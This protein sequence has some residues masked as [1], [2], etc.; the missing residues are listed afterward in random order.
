MPFEDIELNGLAEH[1]SSSSSGSDNSKNSVDEKSSSSGSSSSSASSTSSKNADTVKKSEIRTSEVKKTSGKK[2]M[3]KKTRL[4]LAIGIPVAI[5]VILIIVLCACLCT[6]KI[7][8][9]TVNGNTVSCGKGKVNGDS[10]K[11]AKGLAT[12]DLGDFNGKF[13]KDAFDGLD[14]LT[15]IEVSLTN[16]KYSSKDGVLYDKE[17]KE[18]IRIPKGKSG[19]IELEPSVKTLRSHS[20]KGFKHDITVP[21]E[22]ESIEKGAFGEN[23]DSTLIVKDAAQ[24]TVSAIQGTN[25]FP[26]FFSGKGTVD[27]AEDYP[28]AIADSLR[29]GIDLLKQNALESQQVTVQLFFHTKEDDIKFMSSVTS[30]ADMYPIVK[31]T[32]GAGSELPVY[33]ADVSKI[34][35]VESE[36][37]EKATLESLKEEISFVTY[38]SVTF[39]TFKTSGK[40]YRFD[41]EAGDN[42]VEYIVDVNGSA[43]SAQYYVLPAETDFVVGDTFV[44]AYANNSSS[45]TITYNDKTLVFTNNKYNGEE[46]EITCLPFK[47]P[48]GG[49]PIYDV[50][51][52]KALKA[53]KFSSRNDTDDEVHVN[54]K[55]PLAIDVKDGEINSDKEYTF[56]VTNLGEETLNI[57]ITKQGGSAE[58]ASYKGTTLTGA[59][60]LTTYNLDCKNAESGVNTTT[61]CTITLKAAGTGGEKHALSLTT[62]TITEAKTATLTVPQASA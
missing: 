20:V 37:P 7:A 46:A 55:D 48:T 43:A 33:A 29:W 44:F 31:E 60:A 58:T 10:L 51:T 52:V 27:N 28:K 15:V 49:K 4:G 21:K 30:T 5:V 42:S 47:E 59:D 54:V 18:L 41:V 36:E 24:P 17:A 3:S 62:D 61:T 38:G 13:S 50:C 56:T 26:S 19:N 32:L 9:C 16:E 25:L 2:K 8:E 35:F 14:E 11:D 53:G 1:S 34:R 57:S 40:K 45:V 39:M 22:L 12:L 6:E 23:I